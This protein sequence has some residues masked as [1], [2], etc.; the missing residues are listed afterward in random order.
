MEPKQG[1]KVRGKDDRVRRHLWRKAKM[2]KLITSHD[3][4]IR[5]VEL[6]EQNGKVGR[7]SLKDLVMID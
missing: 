5:N 3:R 7:R 4:E 6:K 1:Q 2:E